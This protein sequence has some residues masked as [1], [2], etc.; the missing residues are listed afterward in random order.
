VA[1]ERRD[2]EQASVRRPV[3]RAHAVSRAAV[4]CQVTAAKCKAP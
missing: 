4:A 2:L 3:R 1:V